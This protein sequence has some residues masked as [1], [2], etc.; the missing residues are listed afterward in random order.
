M[1]ESWRRKWKAVRK[2]NVIVWKGILFLFFR[3]VDGLRVRNSRHI[4]H[5]RR[6]V[7]GKFV[8][9]LNCSWYCIQSGHITATCFNRTRS[10]NVTWPVYIVSLY[11]YIVVYWRYIIHYTNFGCNPTQDLW[12]MQGCWPPERRF[13]I[14]TDLCV[15]VYIYNFIYLFIYETVNWVLWK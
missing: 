5:P 8:R 13:K 12:S 4:R 14:L 11:W 15:C 7:F 10:R 2:W 6:F 9:K 1:E 3:D